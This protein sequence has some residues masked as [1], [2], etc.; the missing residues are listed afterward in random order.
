MVTTFSNIFSHPVG[1]LFILLMVSLLS[2]AQFM[3]QVQIMASYILKDSNPFNFSHIFHH[4]FNNHIY[5]SN[6]SVV[7]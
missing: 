6:T 1:Y 4:T 7:I 5:H 2:N 3:S